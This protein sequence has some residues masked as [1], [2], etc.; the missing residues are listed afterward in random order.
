MVALL[1]SAFLAA[2]TAASSS[3]PVVVDV[4]PSPEARSAAALLAA[5]LPPHR[6]GVVVAAGRVRWADDFLGALPQETPRVVVTDLSFYDEADS[7][8]HAVQVRHNILMVMVDSP[9][10]L[11]V[12]KFH[13][14]AISFRRVLLWC[15]TTQPAHKILENETFLNH[16]TSR[17]LCSHQTTL[18]LSNADGTTTLYALGNTRG[19]LDER[20]QELDRW[21]PA[22]QRWLQGAAPFHPFC[23]KWR[24]PRSPKAPL[25]L[26]VLALNYSESPLFKLSFDLHSKIKLPWKVKLVDILVDKTVSRGQAITLAPILLHTEQCRLDGVLVNR[27]MT[28]VTGCDELTGLLS[29]E[30]YGIAVFVPA[31][32]GPAVNLL[33]AVLAEFSP[34][35]WLGTALAALSTAAALAC[36]LRR[37]RGAALLL[38]LAP[39]LAQAPGTLPPAGH[40]LRPLLGLWLLVCV[41]LVAAYQGLLLG[42]LSTAQPRGEINS[43]QDLEASGLPVVVGPES[44]DFVEPLI[45]D[46]LYGRVEIFQFLDANVVISNNVVLARNCAVITSLDRDLSRDIQVWLSPK[47]KLHFFLVGARHTTTVGYWHRGSPVGEAITTIVGRTQSAGLLEHYHSLRDDQERLAMAKYTTSLGI[48]RPL[49]LRQMCPAF[50]F[51]G[52]GLVLGAASFVVEVLVTRLLTASCERFRASLLFG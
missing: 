14:A 50:L 4:S 17:R 43:L 47:K 52:G 19:C 12:E 1:I 10:D 51:L 24:P 5:F 21:A 40:A 15:S 23:G 36:T 8:A 49:S 34:A 6:A 39:L 31:G 33:D 28:G 42:K 18:A 44:F 22:D 9:E 7:L 13:H 30:P 38:A 27:P 45:P 20:F 48:A 25:N 46:E 37:D 3:L 16:V 29:S 26:F 32:L 35:V 2:A 11:A 41:V